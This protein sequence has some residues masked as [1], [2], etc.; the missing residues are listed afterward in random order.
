MEKKFFNRELSWLEFNGRVLHQALDANLPL[1][2]RLKFLSIVSSNFDE[3][4]QVRVASVKR[5]ASSSPRKRN[6]SG[7]TPKTLLHQISSHAHEIIKTQHMCL[8]QDIIPSLAEKGIR[9]IPTSDYTTSQTEYA[10]N[11]FKNEIFPLLTPLRTDSKEFPHVNNLKLHIAFLLTP[12]EGVGTEANKATDDDS[13]HIALVQIP[14]SLQSIV[15]LPVE[16][17]SKDEKQFTLLNDIIELYAAQ[18][19]PGFSVRE[20]LFFKVMRDADFAVDED[21]DKNFI[22]A[23]ETVL[24]KRQSS[25]A[26]AMICNDSS[27]SIKNFLCEKLALAEEDVYTV[28]DIIDPAMLAELYNSDENVHLSNPEWNHF[29]PPDLPKKE[30]LWSTLKQHDVLL[31]VP[32]E[33]YEPVVKFITDAV[34]DAN[35]L[36]IKMTLYRTGNESPIVAALEKAARNGKQVTVLVELK[37][38]FDEERNIAWAEQLEQAGAIVIYGLVNLKVHAKILYIIRREGDTLKRYVHLSTGNYNTKTA[39]LYSDL[40]IFTAHPEIADDATV[41]FNLVTGYSTLQP[42]KHLS[43]AP[44]TLKEK[45]LSLIEREIEHA[46]SGNGGLIVA[47]MNSLTH[48][49]I[50]SALYKASCAGVKIMLNVRGICM[51][52][53]GI[54]K[55]SENISVVSIVDRYLEHARILY[56]QNNGTPELYLTSADWMP[57]NLERRVELMFPILDKKI[58]S[59]VKKILDT[60]FDDNTNSHELN[61]DGNWE[62]KKTKE[63]GNTAKRAQE[64]LYNHYKCIAEETSSEPEREFKVRRKN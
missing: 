29:Y 63:S 6:I 1:M 20:K 38:R 19:F 56:F 59:E 30:P 31:H 2:E 18:L 37:A 10:L 49:E 23:M 3:F 34:N 9:Y 7:F 58:F 54:Q 5:L 8:M 24:A 11:I 52:V 25:F 46:K 44:V 57:R 21:A 47:K 4:F 51:L 28:S 50:I 42:M 13:Q 53:P 16:E 43:V 27:S 14:S 41:F 33:S 62:P 64:I 40:S 39:K 26:V 15:W 35:V 61:S 60:Y 12:I 55:M 32:Y 17:K 48:E 45:I 36:A 22:N